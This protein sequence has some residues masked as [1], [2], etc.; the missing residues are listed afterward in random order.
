MFFS[1]LVAGLLI[2]FFNVDDGKNE[3]IGYVIAILIV[4]F[5]LNFAYSWG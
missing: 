3:A 4:L 5:V 2:Q 1:I